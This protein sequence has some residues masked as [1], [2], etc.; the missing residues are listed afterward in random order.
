[1]TA[2]I[3]A[4]ARRVALVLATFLAACG[5]ACT[6]CAGSAFADDSYTVALSVTDCPDALQVGDT[7]TVT[8][9][10][11]KDGA[12]SFPLYALSTTVSYDSSVLELVSC[13]RSTMGD[14]YSDSGK[15]IYNVYSQLLAGLTT[16]SGAP[17]YTATFKV[18]GES[19]T[20]IVATRVNMSNYT[21]MRSM[22]TTAYDLTVNVGGGQATT[23]EESES[24]STEGTA[25]EEDNKMGT[26]DALVELIK[27]EPAAALDIEGNLTPSALQSIYAAGMT[28][29]DLV[30]L[31]FNKNELER[32]E[33]GETLAP[34]TITPLV[35]AEKEDVN[36]GSDS[37]SHADDPNGNPALFIVLAVVAVIAVAAGAAVAIRKRK[38]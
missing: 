35:V 17:L 36:M 34:S 37:D 13:E 5:L 30:A 12:D 4:C 11:A 27:K 3:N 28:R 16:Q 1:M 7:F 10:I 19:P 23:P 18:V 8:Q 20:S 31:G 38:K 21:G 33:Q 29:D 22:P 9:T 25:T 2:G 24:G 32:V 26:T 6:L 14:V 15:I